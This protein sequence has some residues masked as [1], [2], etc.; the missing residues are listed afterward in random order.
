MVTTIVLA[1]SCTTSHNYPFFFVVRTF[2]IYSLSK[3][4][5]YNTMLLTIVTMLYIRSP[6]LIHHTTRSVTFDQHLFI[7]PTSQPLVTTILPFVSKSLAFLDSTHK[8]SICLSLSDLFH[9]AQCL[10]VSSILLQM[11][12]FPSLSWLNNMPLCIY[13]PNLL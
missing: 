4:Q 5:V 3:F 10:Q 13:T 6:G 1:K 7:S 11:T 8:C 9:L 12:G 2:K